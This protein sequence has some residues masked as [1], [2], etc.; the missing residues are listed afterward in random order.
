[1]GRPLAF[2]MGLFLVGSIAMFIP[3]L[4][5]SVSVEEPFLSNKINVLKLSMEVVLPLPLPPAPPCQLGNF[6]PSS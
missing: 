1:M 5:S 4:T 2:W 3:G 6:V